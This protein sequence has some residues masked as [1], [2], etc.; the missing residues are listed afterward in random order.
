MAETSL[1]YVQ[2]A[3]S[4]DHY[5]VYSCTDL[6][7]RGWLAASPTR[8]YTFVQNRVAKIQELS[9]IASWK[10]VHLSHD[11]S[12]DQVSRGVHGSELVKSSLWW[13]GPHWQTTPEQLWINSQFS[14]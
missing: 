11:N 9:G 5:K 1:Q 10:H 13:N 12:T 3:L 4:L 6:Q 14:I 2:S 8:W 7:V